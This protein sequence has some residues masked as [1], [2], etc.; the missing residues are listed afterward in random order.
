MLISE[1]EISGVK[2]IEPK[3]FE[4]SRGFFLECFQQDRYREAGITDTFIQDNHSRSTAGVLRGMHYQVKDPQ[5]Q[6]LTVVRGRIFDVVVDLR[7]LSKTFGQWFGTVLS[8]DGPCQIYMAPGIA[9]GFCVL[10]DYADLHYKVSRFYDPADEGGLIW[11]DPDIGIDWP[12]NNPI[13]SSK[14]SSFSRF[15][16]IPKEQLPRAST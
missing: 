15:A 6:I 2:L 11:N 5:A 1:T 14:D 9:H 10:S 7:P 4:D 8:D 16:N 12:I 13:V 3:R